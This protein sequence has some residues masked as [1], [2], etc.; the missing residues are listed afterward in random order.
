MFA[1]L[2]PLCRIAVRAALLKKHLAAHCFLPHSRLNFW[3]LARKSY[4]ESFMGWRGLE[5]CLQAEA[6]MRYAA[7]LGQPALALFPLENCPWERMLTHALRCATGKQPPAHS[8]AAQQASPA[9]QPTAQAP[10]AALCIIGVQH[11]T[12]RPTD[13]RYFD[14]PRFFT[15]PA[16]QVLVPDKLVLNGE[17]AGQQL[18]KAGTAATILYHAEAL[19][20]QHNNTASPCPDNFSHIK[21]SQCSTCTAQRAR[22]IPRQRGTVPLPLCRKS[23]QAFLLKKAVAHLA[24][25]G[26][27]ATGGLA[28]GVVLKCTPA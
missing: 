11:S 6:C 2:P 5:R 24:L 19:R 4:A 8:A 12:L 13:W 18:L 16:T 14:D 25:L 20:F 23:Y 21:Q 10:S 15:H 3:L 9:A 26:Q 28:H 1:P 22:S 27:A 17:H 7:W